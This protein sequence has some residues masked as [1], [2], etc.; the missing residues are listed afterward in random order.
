MTSCGTMVVG[1]KNHGQVR[2]RKYFGGRA[3]WVLQHIEFERQEKSWKG[4]KM[5]SRILAC[6]L[7]RGNGY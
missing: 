3:N 2:F 1:V 7:V 4:L 5:P 6:S